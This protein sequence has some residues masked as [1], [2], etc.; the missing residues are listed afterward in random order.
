M[1][2]SRDGWISAE[3]DAFPSVE[4]VLGYFKI[5]DLYKSYYYWLPVLVPYFL[6]WLFPKGNFH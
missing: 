1:P 5:K 2:L 3:Y 6:Y 4:I